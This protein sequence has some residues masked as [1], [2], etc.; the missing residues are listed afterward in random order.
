MKKYKILITYS[1]TDD[2]ENFVKFAKSIKSVQNFVL[3]ILD[4]RDK[5]EEPK[6]IT[7]D[8]ENIE[9]HYIAVDMENRDKIFQLTYNL[10]HQ[11][12]ADFFM[13]V[14]Q[15]I[16]LTKTLDV[17]FRDIFLENPNISIL[18]PDFRLQVKNSRKSFV[19]V[20]FKSRPA[21]ISNA[22]IVIFRNYPKEVA[23]QAEQNKLSYIDFLTRAFIV[24]HVPEVMADVLLK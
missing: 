1:L 22:P 9:V 4:L 15:G 23:A 16:V 24:K 3:Y 6:E 19:Q 10:A 18:I 17:L 7:L 11:N 14:S 2:Y 20:L 21:N 5:Q 8:L 13:H 12:Q